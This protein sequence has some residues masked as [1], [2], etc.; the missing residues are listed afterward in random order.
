MSEQEFI[1]NEGLGVEEQI[2]VLQEGNP[3]VI[4][5]VELDVV[6]NT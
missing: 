3:T 2:E 5:V 1:Q 4:V 6:T